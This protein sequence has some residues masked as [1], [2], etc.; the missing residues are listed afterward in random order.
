MYTNYAETNCVNVMLSL[1]LSLNS[2]P[3]S[4]T[5]YRLCGL[6]VS[7][8]VCSGSDLQYIAA[9]S[10]SKAIRS[11]ASGIPAYQNFLPFIV[12]LIIFQEIEEYR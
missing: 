10:G 9:A 2:P 7:V 3:R 12:I 1:S 11:W 5:M 8:N 6:N 4:S